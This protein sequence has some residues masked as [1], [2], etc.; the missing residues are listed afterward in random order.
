MHLY[1]YLLSFQRVKAQL[2][3]RLYAPVVFHIPGSLLRVGFRELRQTLLPL[4]IIPALQ[5][6][7]YTECRQGERQFRRCRSIRNTALRIIGIQYLA[8]L[9]RLGCWCTGHRTQTFMIREVAN[10]EQA[11]SIGHCICT[12]TRQG[13]VTLQGILANIIGKTN[14]PL[15]LHK[16]E[17]PP[18]GARKG[19]ITRF[20]RIC[21]RGTWNL[22]AQRY[23]GK[24]AGHS[25]IGADF[26]GT[27]GGKC[28]SPQ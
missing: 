17:I 8:H 12:N 24:L 3:H 28:C 22:N 19:H 18:K 27:V 26:L 11:A 13:A 15:P 1:G 6:T 7:N 5:Y 25:R 21:Q 14:L 23:M 20:Q 2:S 9:P 16:A 4:S 10:Q